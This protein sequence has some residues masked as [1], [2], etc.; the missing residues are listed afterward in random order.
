MTATVT[1]LAA[2]RRAHAAHYNAVSIVEAS[3]LRSVRFWCDV[4]RES[5]RFWM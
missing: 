2:W 4:W 5:L 3:A 1:D